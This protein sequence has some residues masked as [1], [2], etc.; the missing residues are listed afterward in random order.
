MRYRQLLLLLLPVGGHKCGAPA[1][2]LPLQQVEERCLDSEAAHAESAQLMCQCPSHSL[3][4][5]VVGEP[6]QGLNIS[7]TV[8]TAKMISR[9]RLLPQAI[10]P[11][12]ALE[13]SGHAAC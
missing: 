10:H 6:T 7:S 3:L 4:L 13:R 8:M 5:V 1:D 12:E 11:T 9:M 2:H